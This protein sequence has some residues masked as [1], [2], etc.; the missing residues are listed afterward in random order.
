MKIHK[1]KSYIF[2]IFYL[3]SFR[4]LIEKWNPIALNERLLGKLKNTGVFEE[5]FH[6]KISPESFKN[7]HKDWFV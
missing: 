4:E 1:V 3:G 7:T 2:D 5:W 6:G